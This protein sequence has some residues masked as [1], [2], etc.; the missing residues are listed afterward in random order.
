MKKDQNKMKIKVANL[1][2]K[3]IIMEIFEKQN[4]K[5]IIKIYIF[6]SELFFILE[7][8]IN[9]IKSGIFIF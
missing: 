6:I 7:K 2:N 3:L 5:K 1:A 4:T 8:R 9:F